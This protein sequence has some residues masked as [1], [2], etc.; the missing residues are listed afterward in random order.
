MVS[1]KV[2]SLFSGFVNEMLN[3]SNHILICN[4]NT[5]R[6]QQ[7]KKSTET[8]RESEKKPHTPKYNNNIKSI[9]YFIFFLVNTSR[10]RAR[11]REFELNMQ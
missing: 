1:V 11:D 7:S 8:V 5:K 2:L 6:Q 3:H 10:A 9:H 4:G